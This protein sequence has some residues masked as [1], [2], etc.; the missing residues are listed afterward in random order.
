LQHHL[1]AVGMAPALGEDPFYVAACQETGS[2]V[3]FEHDIH[4]PTN[5]DI[6]PV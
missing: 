4:Q 6:S 3:F 1:D 2:L 5:L